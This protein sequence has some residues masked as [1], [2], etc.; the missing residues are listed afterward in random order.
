MRTIP[1]K[2]SSMKTGESDETKGVPHS[3]IRLDFGI[4]PAHGLGMALSVDKVAEDALELSVS[5]RALLVEKLLASLA[6][7]ANPEVQRTHLG[8][9]R[10][11]RE[12]VRSGK[13][14]L[15]DGSTA[16]QQARA[17]VRS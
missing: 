13:S 15:A 2:E 12:A 17:A 3:D 16:L 4:H 7:Q 14:K 6:G 8:E 10:R 9:I 1:D 11:R 5:G